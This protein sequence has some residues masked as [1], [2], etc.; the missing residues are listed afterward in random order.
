MEGV[1][2]TRVGYAG[3]KKKAPTYASIGDHTETVQ[4][5]YDPQRITYERLLEIIWESHRPDGRNRSGQYMNAIFYH[6]G[7]QKRTALASKAA[8]EKTT[9]RAVT[10]RILPV[11]SFTLAEDYHQKYLLKQNAGLMRELMRIYPRHEDLVNSTAA[12]RMNG[13]AGGYGSADR[14]AGELPDLGLSPDGQKILLQI[15]R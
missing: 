12:A 13:Y 1:I 9:G 11:R 7:D 5:D 14:L 10:T 3:G 8:L 6:D 15:A 4:L 2:R